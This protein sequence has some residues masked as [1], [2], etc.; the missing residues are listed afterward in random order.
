MLIKYSLSVL[1]VLLVG[2]SALAEDTLKT[3][4]LNSANPA[5]P[6]AGEHRPDYFFQRIV[7]VDTHTALSYNTADRGKNWINFRSVDKSKPAYKAAVSNISWTTE[8]NSDWLSIGSGGQLLASLTTADV[9]KKISELIPAD[10]LIVANKEPFGPGYCLGKVLYSGKLGSIDRLPTADGNNR[11]NVDEIVKDAVFSVDSALCFGPVSSVPQVQFATSDIRA[12]NETLLVI[13]GLYPI[14][15]KKKEG[16]ETD[17]IC[18][19]TSK[20]SV[21]SG[22]QPQ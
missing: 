7:Q 13:S 14:D 12:L 10:G 18:E 22:L 9:D 16:S 2:S 17:H 8:M 4:H 3:W 5:L 21:V 19:F 1:A 20:G 11:I 6:A 15:C